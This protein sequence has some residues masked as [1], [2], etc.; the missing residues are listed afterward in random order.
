MF[1]RQ[2][3]KNYI[4]RNNCYQNRC[5]QK[6]WEQFGFCIYTNKKTRILYG[7]KDEYIFM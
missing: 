7:K 3:L 5:L 4:S 1:H 6:N 2:P